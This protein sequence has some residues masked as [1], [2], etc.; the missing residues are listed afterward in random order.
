[1]SKKLTILIA[2]NDLQ[3]LTDA[4]YLLCFAKKVAGESYDI[5]WRAFTKYF[6]NNVFS[7]T[8]HYKLLS[9]NAFIAGATPRSLTESTAIQIGQQTT[10][11][12]AGVF[13]SPVTGS[14][15]NVLEMTNQYGKIYPGVCQTSTGIDNSIIDTPIYIS[16][17]ANV[18]GVITFKPIEK[19]LVWFEQGV[20]TST[21]FSVPPQ[22]GVSRMA[23]TT[24]QSFATEV[25]MTSTDTATRKYEN[26]QWSTPP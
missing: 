9:T 4:G 17:Q 24:G 15:P 13:S 12:S 1:M 16:Q 20:K 3:D 25:V 5:V 26:Y 23:P 14:N 10:L 19:A 11:D 21:M 7:W 6:T 18:P 8:S 22:L 2:A